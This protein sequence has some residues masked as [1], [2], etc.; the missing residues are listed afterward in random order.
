MVLPMLGKPTDSE[1]AVATAKSEPS[2]TVIIGV[3]VGRDG[4]T[5]CV[6]RHNADGTITI[7]EMNQWKHDI[8]LEPNR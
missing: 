2:G 7:L 5:S 1:I 3:D 8:N 4:S 6:A